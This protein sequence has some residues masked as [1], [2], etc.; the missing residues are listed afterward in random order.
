MPDFLAVFVS[1]FVCVLYNV[2]LC[3][4]Y[5]GKRPSIMPRDTSLSDS[6]YQIFSSVFVCFSSVFMF[7]SFVSDIK[8]CMV[9]YNGRQNDT[10]S[11]E[12]KVAET[13][14]AL[15]TEKSF[16][17]LVKSTRNRIAFTMHRVIWNQTDDDRL[18]PNHSVISKYNLIS[19]W[20]DKISKT[21]LCVWLQTKKN[22]T[23]DRL[24][25]LGIMG[26]G[27]LKP[28][29]TIDKVLW[30]GVWGVSGP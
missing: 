5:N 21:L 14:R 4:W 16:P 11:R 24:A 7:F 28:L 1:N 8:F 19:V 12:V 3:V 10:F 2:F 23:R 9:C 27:P 15:R 18:V 6:G 29:N 20:F 22:L 13:L 25:S 17:N 30:D 26:R